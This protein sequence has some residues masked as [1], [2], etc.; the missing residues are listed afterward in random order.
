[1]ARARV[2]GRLHGCPQRKRIE[3]AAVLDKRFEIGEA[4]GDQRAARRRRRIERDGC[5]GV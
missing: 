4:E 5:A 3:G 2:V 1:M